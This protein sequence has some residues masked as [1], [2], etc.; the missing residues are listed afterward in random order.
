MHKCLKGSRNIVFRE[1]TARPSNLWNIEISS[2]ED[3]PFNCLNTG[4]KKEKTNLIRKRYTKISFLPIWQFYDSYIAIMNRT[5][6]CSITKL[7][8]ILGKCT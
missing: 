2:Y 3:T 8:N 5:L 4:K 1:N 6:I 7:H